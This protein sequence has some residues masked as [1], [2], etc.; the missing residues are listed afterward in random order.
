[1]NTWGLSEWGDVANIVIAIAS[2]ATA[3]VTAIVL[4]KQRNDN[5]KEKHSVNNNLCCFN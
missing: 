5:I 2:V 4:F 3:I 1:M